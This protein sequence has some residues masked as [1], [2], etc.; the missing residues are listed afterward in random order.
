MTQKF[1]LAAQISE[2][3]FELSMRARVY[4][5]RV[6][7]GLLRQGEADM[8]VAILENVR[9]TL[10]FMRDNEAAIRAVFAKEQP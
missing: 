7:R 3:D 9:A 2:I 5:H 10:V 8:H 6:A 4:P 1:T